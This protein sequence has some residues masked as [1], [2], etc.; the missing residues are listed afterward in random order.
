M[1][2]Q[3]SHYLV[4]CDPGLMTGLGVIDVTDMDNP[5]PLMAWEVSLFEF[6]DTMEEIIEKTKDVKVTIVYE[7]FIITPETAK[8]TPQPYSLW[9]IGVMQYLCYKHDMAFEVQKPADKAFI[10]NTK[11]GNT[12]LRKV[13]FWYKGG[14]GH[15]NDMY[16]HAV[17]WLVNNNPN[18]A[19]NLLS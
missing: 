5:R 13:G 9:L 6:Y 7:D 18:W 4:A 11:D 15:A 12:K 8:K 10:P 14:A 1:Q 3:R 17:V 19:K 2:K 16:R